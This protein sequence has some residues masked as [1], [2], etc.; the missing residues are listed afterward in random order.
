MILEEPG[1]TNKKLTYLLQVSFLFLLFDYSNNILA[2]FHFE[3]LYFFMPT[4]QAG[5]A[6]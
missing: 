4:T 3:I 1:H 6:M 5:T 2:S